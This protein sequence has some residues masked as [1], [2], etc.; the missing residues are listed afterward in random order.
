MTKEEFIN[1]YT[2]DILPNFCEYTQVR[3]EMLFDL[4]KVITAS[5]LHQHKAI[6]ALPD[7]EEIERKAEFRQRSRNSK[8]TAKD[9]FIYGFIQGAEWIIDVISSNED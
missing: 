9:E 8:N 4:E 3:E 1:K 2:D 6:I 5:K 7:D